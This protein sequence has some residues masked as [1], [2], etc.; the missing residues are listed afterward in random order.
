MKRL[1]MVVALVSTNAM[2]LD[3]NTEWAK[4]ADDFAKLKSKVSVAVDVPKSKVEPVIVPVEDAEVKQVD[5]KSPER[6]GLKL[7]D[8]SMV[9]KLKDLY[10]RDDVVVYSTTVR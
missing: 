2:A 10:Q 5:P 7:S 4:F 8:A 6:L 3:F 9:K 1:V